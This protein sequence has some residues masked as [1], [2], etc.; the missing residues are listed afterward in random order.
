MSMAASIESRVP[1]LDHEL[2]Q[3]SVGLPGRMK[4]RGSTT[5][6]VLRESMKGVLPDRILTR[7]KMGFPVPVGRWLRTSHRHVLDEYVLG[8]RAAGRGLFD[9]QHTSR[10]VAEHLAGAAN[11]SERLWALVNLELWMR[12]YLDGE[13]RTGDLPDVPEA[14][15]A[16][17]AA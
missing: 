1:F 3:Y 17:A 16:R 2:V 13:A 5:K 14:P 12:Q 11:H 7:P 15:R 8:A 10:L 9:R 4:L 6:Y